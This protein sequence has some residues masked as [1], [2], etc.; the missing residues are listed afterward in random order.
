M[1]SHTTRRAFIGQVGGGLVIGILLP[2]MV[3]GQAIRR[4]DAAAMRAVPAAPNADRKS[5]V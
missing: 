3:R 2:T 4:M 1:A 5:V